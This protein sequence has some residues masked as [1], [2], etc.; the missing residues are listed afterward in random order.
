M[1]IVQVI[2]LLQLNGM[3]MLEKDF[4]IHTEGDRIFL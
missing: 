1:Y 3:K 4:V 2:G